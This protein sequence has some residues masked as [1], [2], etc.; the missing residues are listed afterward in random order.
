[1]RHIVD[2]IDRPLLFWLNR[3]NILPQYLNRDL[4]SEAGRAYWLGTL[5]QT[6]VEGELLPEEVQ[7]LSSIVNQLAEEGLN[8]RLIRQWLGYDW[9]M[10]AIADNDSNQLAS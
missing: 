10:H 5:D 8:D 1:M 4:S 3:H 9:N 7:Q 6:E 2:A